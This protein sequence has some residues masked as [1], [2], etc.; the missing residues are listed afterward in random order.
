MEGSLG[1]WRSGAGENQA[2]QQKFGLTA[3][4][5][6]VGI[7]ER[8][9][10]NRSTADTD[11]QRPVGMTEEP[12]IRQVRLDPAVKIRSEGRADARNRIGDRQARGVMGD[13]N[14]LSVQ[15]LAIS[16]VNQSR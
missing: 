11:R 7:A 10:D 9:V 15:G 13:D 1:E 8:D 6:L 4:G 3:L 14:G 2:A 12:V 16:R 5:H